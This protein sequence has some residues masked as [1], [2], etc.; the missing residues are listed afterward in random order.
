MKPDAPSKDNLEAQTGESHEE[1]G[2]E[3]TNFRLLISAFGLHWMRDYGYNPS[4]LLP[5][6]SNFSVFSS[7]NIDVMSCSHGNTCDVNVKLYIGKCDGEV[8][9]GNLIN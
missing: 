3:G 1:R 7:M 2:E 9:Q 5:T 4:F 8:Q 6:C